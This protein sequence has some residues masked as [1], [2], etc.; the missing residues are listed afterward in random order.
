MQQALPMIYCPNLKC[1]A[2]NP[3]GE[4]ACH[5]CGTRL[6]NRYLW[7]VGLDPE[8]ETV[9][10]LLG[11]RYPF[12]GPQVV[13]ETQP[14]LPL[15]SSFDITESIL[16]YL[17]LFPW[18][19][20]L[21]QLYSLLTGERSLLLLE[22]APLSPQDFNIPSPAGTEKGDATVDFTK[23][24]I[25]ENFTDAWKQAPALRQ[26]NWLWQM[27]QLWAPLQ[28]EGVAS[29]LID[30]QLLRV[31]G[32]LLRLLSLN[33]QA[34]LVLPLSELG[35]FW[36]KW[37]L[38]SVGRWQTKFTELCD[39]LM[40]G[41]IT[42]PDE[43]IENLEAWLAAVRTTSSIQVDVA[44]R[45][46][47]GPTREHNEDACYPHHGAVAQNASA[48]L[49]VVCDGVG[50][51][52]GG[53]VASGLAIKTITEYLQQTPLPQLTPAELIQEL[54]TGIGLANDQIAQQNDQE[55]R[56]DRDRMGTTLVMALAQNQDLYISNL[57]DSRAY[58]ITEQACYQ[59]TTDD[60]IAT[61]EVRLGY[62]PH[63]EAMRQ[64]G[65]GSLIQAL[66]MVPSSML[67][68]ATTRFLLDSDCLFLLCSDGLSDFE[69][70]ESL[71]REELLPL[72]QGKIDLAET[73]KRLIAAA[74]RFNGHDNVTVALMHCHQ[75]DAST[76]KTAITATSDQSQK[77][78]LLKTQL[79]DRPFT[80]SVPRSTSI[81]P[82]AIV[83]FLT[84]FGLGAVLAYL[85]R[86]SPKPD[87]TSSTGSPQ[88][89]AT[90]TASAEP[91][92]PSA[93]DLKPDTYWRIQAAPPATVGN[94]PPVSSSLPI[95]IRSRPDLTLKPL[96]TLPSGSI[97][98]ILETTPEATPE[99]APETKE[100][101]GWKKVQLCYQPPVG[102]VPSPAQ[103]AQGS[104]NATPTPPSSPSVGSTEPPSAES[105]TQPNGAAANGPSD[106]V[107]GGEAS[108]SIQPNQSG[109]VEVTPFLSRARRV[110]TQA[111]EPSQRAGCLAEDD[112]PS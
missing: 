87:A 84:V 11:D 56:H 67:R 90:G 59:I 17:K 32:P 21:P 43:L 29:S 112:A 12:R 91:T 105:P 3:E 1:R 31:E 108:S 58:L 102:A 72:L 97:L 10:N 4:V 13:V 76:A 86:P 27:A 40:E 103:S 81:L 51:H 74:N 68:P 45:T 100:V 101:S 42:A 83:G 33:Y 65:A 96:A 50:G 99:A 64:P 6:P 62:L 7:V 54:E 93:A 75:V 34:N 89:T 22:G 37:C 88:P 19:L 41:E 14:G 61:R 55:N 30:P 25:A 82:W 36:A 78:T 71:W 60:D 35:R 28:R 24:A 107:K 38:P 9:E 70:V 92:S 44:T 48:G 2:A 73:T 57:G 66:G 49:M 26:V 63:R 104:A 79:R 5:Q 53:E 98:K 69:R 15:A 80:K 23:I 20:H 47:S 18:R 8:V 85:L 106:R 52:A 39:Q 46:D 111:L 110:E 109:Y 94:P 16:P 95:A 77:P